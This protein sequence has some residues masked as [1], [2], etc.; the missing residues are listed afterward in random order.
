MAD[1][2]YLS[3]GEEMPDH[4]DDEPWL[5]IDTTEEGPFQGS[6]ASRKPSG[7]WVGYR[8][9]SE[10]DTSLEAALEAA[11]QWAGENGVPTIWVRSEP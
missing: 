11:Q 3:A 9:L 8:S 2:V 7:E 1:V 5:I 6:G 4:G 10:D